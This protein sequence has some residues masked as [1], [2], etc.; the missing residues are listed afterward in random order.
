MTEHLE[1]LE[2]G[3]GGETVECSGPGRWGNKGGRRK[4][5]KNKKRHISLASMAQYPDEK[6]LGIP[7]V[8][9]FITVTTPE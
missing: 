8:M 4:G 3:G 1:Q 2:E 5:D 9:H 7:F 6:L